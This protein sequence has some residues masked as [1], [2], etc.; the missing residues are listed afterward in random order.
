MLLGYCTFHKFYYVLV[1]TAGFTYLQ[2]LVTGRGFD[3]TP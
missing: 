1:I 2:F 3:Q